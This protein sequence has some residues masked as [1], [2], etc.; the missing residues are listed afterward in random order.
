MKNRAARIWH[1][2]DESGA[3]KGWSNAILTKQKGM[4][5]KPTC[6]LNQHVD[7]DQEDEIKHH[8]ENR[9]WKDILMA[10]ERKKLG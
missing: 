8:M 1:Q 2:E 4:K 10:I 3:D 5:T 6:R 7:D 9:R